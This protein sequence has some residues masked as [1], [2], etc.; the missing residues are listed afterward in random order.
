MGVPEWRQ[1]G[2]PRGLIV[3]EAETV[4]ASLLLPEEE[5]G[6]EEE[7]EGESI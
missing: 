7:E 5:E 6:E 3:G 2:G 4:T 1:P